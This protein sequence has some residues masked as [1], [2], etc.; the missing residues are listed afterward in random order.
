MALSEP[1]APNADGKYVRFVFNGDNHPGPIGLNT[2][3]NTRDLTH[4]IEMVMDSPD[5]EV[6]K[7]AYL[8]GEGGYQRV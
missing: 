7:E 6:D 1:T 2:A 4:L 3:K 5:W 8:V